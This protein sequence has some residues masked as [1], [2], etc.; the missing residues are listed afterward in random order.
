MS[1]LLKVKHF[2]TGIGVS[3][4]EHMEIT[5]IFMEIH[6]EVKTIPNLQIVRLPNASFAVLRNNEPVVKSN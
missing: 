6:M 5:G 3:N 2:T 1:H 4:T